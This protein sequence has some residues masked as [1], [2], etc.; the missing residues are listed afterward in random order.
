ML[1]SFAARLITGRFAR[2]ERGVS[3]VEF[4][5]LLPLLVTLYLGGVELSQAIAIDRKVTLTARTVADL[6]SQ[7]ASINNAGLDNSLTAA[8]A[9]LS[10][11]P[12]NKAKV[13]VTFVW[14][15]KDKNAKVEWS[16]SLNGT[17]R[18]KG[19]S[20]TVPSAL[21]VPETGL[22]WG[23]AEYSYEP[24]VGYVVTGTLKLADQIFMRPRLG[25]KVIKP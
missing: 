10:P 21:L 18:A 11:Y 23:E 8:S 20:A 22:V 16:K 17:E 13:T 19:S 12:V 2:D 5:L 7:V 15:D 3:A 24:A 6:V 4:A 1:R 9:V 25:D 14:I